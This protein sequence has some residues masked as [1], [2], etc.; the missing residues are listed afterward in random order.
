MSSLDRSV[1]TVS[2]AFQS[3]SQVA[4]AGTGVLELRSE[5]S[6]PIEPYSTQGFDPPST[7]GDQSSPRLNSIGQLSG[8]TGCPSSQWQGSFQT[9]I[10]DSSS[11]SNTAVD[12]S[13]AS[14]LSDIDF[15]ATKR[16]YSESEASRYCEPSW[17]LRAA[18]TSALRIWNPNGVREPE[19]RV[20][21]IEHSRSIHSFD[22]HDI[23]DIWLAADFFAAVGLGNDAFELYKL[24]IQ[25]QRQ[26]PTHLDTSFSHWVHQCIYTAAQPEH[27]EFVQGII[28]Q[29][30]RRLQDGHP[31]KVLFHMLLAS[32]NVRFSNIE[33][34]STH[35]SVASLHASLYASFH[36]A[37][38]DIWF[39]SLL[40][41]YLP[42]TRSLD[43][44]LY[45]AVVRLHTGKGDL[46]SP[47]PLDFTPMD[48]PALKSTY[49]ECILKHQPGP[50]EL[51]QDDRFTNPC[52]Q[53]CVRWCARKLMNFVVLA[54]TPDVAACCP[55]MVSLGWTEA[56]AL[57]FALW[58]H[59]VEDT[60]RY[61]SSRASPTWITE[62]HARMG[63][64]PTLLLML[65]C[66][67]IHGG[68]HNDAHVLA[69]PEAA[70]FAEVNADVFAVPEAELLLRLQGR[71]AE[72]AEVTD[73]ELARLFLGQY[74]L[75]HTL[76]IDSNRRRQIQRHERARAAAC[77]CS[78][79]GVVFP[80]LD[81]SAEEGE[82][83]P[84]LVLAPSERWSG[85]SYGNFLETCDR[86]AEKAKEMKAAPT[87]QP[88]QSSRGR[89]GRLGRFRDIFM[90]DRGPE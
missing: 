5:V 36:A 47:G 39:F 83:D 42:A 81:A 51:D 53:G 15:N 7:S 58:K 49:E 54:R 17:P 66:R 12:T 28:H 61:P 70:V 16:G 64:S 21:M 34:A 85:S 87:S 37:G 14:H 52:L 90:R 41:G 68:Y 2:G 8:T 77:L 40:D 22:A 60:P 63:I 9:L 11:R 62:T 29:R 27:M 25:W 79:L 43:L 82:A 73:R 55:D 44:I 38:D 6:W 30:H 86:A 65:V 24:L 48:V 76:T 4:E 3:S 33:E 32:L 20:R 35:I 67:V 74:I 56:T 84:S 89:F 46:L 26:Y 88:S 75:H 18:H 50:F 10:N 69:N 13:S 19:P 71:A 80:E 78:T 57:F 1:P 31:G 23:G 72:L 45:H 59:F